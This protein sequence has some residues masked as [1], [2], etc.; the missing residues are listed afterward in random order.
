MVFK[1]IQ[2]GESGAYRTEPLG[3][4]QG[5]LAP[6]A[7]PLC[8]HRKTS[9]IKAVPLRELVNAAAVQCDSL[10]YARRIHQ[11]YQAYRCRLVLFKAHVGAAVNKWLLE[12]D[13]VELWEST[14]SSRLTISPSRN[15][16]AQWVGEATKKIHM[17][18]DIVYRRPL[19]EKT[20]LAVPPAD[21]S[22]DKLI[23]IEGMAGEFSFMDVYSSPGPF[24][25]ALPASPVPAD[26]DYRLGS[27]DEDNGL[28]DEWCES[29]SGVNSELP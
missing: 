3:G 19:F 17:E 13:Y 29:D 20:G 6:V 21:R 7:A 14:Y 1:D 16:I 25:D 2:S 5:S 4:S 18:M 27:S 24:E 23:N 9:R 28:D 26:E 12:S 10:A 22:Y 11:R 8:R 15:L